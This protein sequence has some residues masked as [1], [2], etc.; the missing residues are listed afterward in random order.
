M[1][2]RLPRV[3]VVDDEAAVR[4]VIVS[5]LE[6]RKIEVREVDSAI[7][8]LAIVPH[9]APTVIITDLRMPEMDGFEFLSQISQISQIKNIPVIVM[10]GHGDKESAIRSVELGAFGFFE[11]PF[12]LDS[13]EVSIKRANES[14]YLHAEKNAL[15]KKLD[16]LCHFQNREI[17]NLN[18]SK[19]SAFIGKSKLIEELRKTLN[20][21]SKKPNATVFIGGET[22]TGKEVAARELHLMTH[23]SLSSI[24]APFVAL[25]CSAIPPDL[26]ESELYGHEKG[27]F[28]GA[29]AQRI[30]LA[31]ATRDGTLF[32]DEIGDM[33]L[34]HQA[35]LLRLV[36]ERKF[37][38]VG[39]SKEIDFRGR[40][41]AATHRNLLKMSQ[42]NLFREDLYY[43]LSVVSVELPPLRKR[44][45]DILLLAEYLCS[46]HGVK[47]VSPERVA[48]ILSY[49]WPGN[50]RELN[51]WIE[52]ASILSK[53][54]SDN[55]VNDALP[56]QESFQSELE[57]AK[58][59]LG[60][61]ENHDFSDIKTKR[62]QLLDEFDRNVIEK[63]LDECEGNLSKTAL[64][65]GLDR[66]N[67]ARRMRELSI[68]AFSHSK[69][70]KRAA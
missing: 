15:L 40:I 23:E 14:F 43:R 68:E 26:L 9:F 65:I 29:T 47:G 3:L 33:D 39:S 64:M 7:S 2:H 57:S 36:Q 69:I 32:L 52:R 54:D 61:F 12:D 1:I 62:T 28:T 67:L 20:Q 49:S 41:V 59:H 27:S 18:R 63:A 22:G 45:S 34:R 6:R 4:K 38:K 8:A 44:G 56:R 30:G 10:T 46:K 19:E 58:S 25:N 16:E 70:R 66:K 37:R 50:I 55:R 48:E 17:E 51:N 42:Q 60:N 31:E 11:K 21:L 53:I 35:K 5:R 24:E 13:L